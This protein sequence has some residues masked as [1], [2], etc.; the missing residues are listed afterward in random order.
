M[1]GA[2]QIH[3]FCQKVLLVIFVQVCAVERSIFWVLE[4]LNVA[5]LAPIS[6]GTWEVQK[7]QEKLMTLDFEALS[8]K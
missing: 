6:R 3:A 2:Q 8:P 1:T 5:H 7:I 4:R